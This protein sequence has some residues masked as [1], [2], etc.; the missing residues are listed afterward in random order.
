MDDGWVQCTDGWEL[1]WN[2]PTGGANDLTF[3]QAMVALDRHTSDHRPS[4]DQ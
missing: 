3:D 4:I 2:Q 1:S